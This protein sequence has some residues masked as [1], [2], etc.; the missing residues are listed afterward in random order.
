MIFLYFLILNLST[1]QIAQ[2]LNLNKDD[3]LA[4]S[5]TWLRPHRGISQEKL[6]LYLG[7]SE[8]VHNVRKRGEAL[9]SVHLR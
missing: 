1:R 6:P 3:A 9:L 4:G 5:D 7:F 8:F 2:E